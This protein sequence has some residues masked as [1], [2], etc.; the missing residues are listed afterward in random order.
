MSQ[1]IHSNETSVATRDGASDVFEGSR[2]VTVNKT[3]SSG[4]GRGSKDL[5][6]SGALV[7]ISLPSTCADVKPTTLSRFTGVAGEGVDG[8]DDEYSAHVGFFQWTCHG[9]DD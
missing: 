6:M 8:D 3:S 7:A 2:R 9:T 1:C 5:Q 4:C